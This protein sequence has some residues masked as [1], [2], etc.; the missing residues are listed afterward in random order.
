[1]LAKYL[2]PLLKKDQKERKLK[3]KERWLGKAQTDRDLQR[4]KNF[5]E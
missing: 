4:I 1:L 5:Q 2:L 3:N